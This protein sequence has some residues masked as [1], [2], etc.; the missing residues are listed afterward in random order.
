M[1]WSVEPIA[2]ISFMRLLTT[3]ISFCLFTQVIAQPCTMQGVYKIG[4]A[5]DYTTIGA[6]LT[7]LRNTGVGG[8][9]I[10]EI[11]SNYTN[12]NE[13][14]LSFGNIPCVS[15]A[16][17]ITL[18]PEAGATGVRISANGAIILLGNAHNVIIDGRPGGMG[19]TSELTLDGVSPNNGTIIFSGNSEVNTLRYVKITS[20]TTVTNLGTITFQN[21]GNNNNYI[22]NCYITGNGNGNPRICIYSESSTVKNLNNLIREC[23]ITRFGPTSGSGTGTGIYLGKN[24][25]GWLVTGNSFYA[26]GGPLAWGSGDIYAINMVDTTSSHS[27]YDNF[28]GGTAPQCGGQQSQVSHRFRGI[29]VAAGRGT[30]TNIDRNTIANLQ[31]SWAGLSGEDFAGIHI[32]SGKVGCGTSGGN[33]I[34]NMQ[35]NE[36]IKVV[37]SAASGGNVTGILLGYNLIGWPSTDTVL[38]INNKIGGIHCSTTGPTSSGMALRGI[39]VAEQKESFITI[40]DNKIG[41]ETLNNSL[42]SS[43]MSGAEVVGIDFWVSPNGPAYNEDYPPSYEIVNNRVAH[44]RGTTT[45]IRVN[46]GKPQ[47]INN[48]IRDM[49]M[50]IN[51]L[52]ILSI[53]GIRVLKA[54]TGSNIKGNRLFNLTLSPQQASGI[55]GIHLDNARGVDIAGNLMHNFQ[56]TSIDQTTTAHLS[57]IEGTAFTNR[58]NIYNNMISMG[59]DS[60][61]GPFGGNSEFIAMQMT[62]DTTNIMHNSIFIAGTGDV[63]A[64]GLLLT[65]KNNSACRVTNNIIQN[66]HS[67]IT[68]NVWTFN[69]AV[70]FDPIFTTTLNG[71]VMDYN[72]YNISGLSSF[73]GSYNNQRYATLPEWRVATAREVNSITGNPN[74]IKPAGDSLTTNMHIVLPTP[75]DAAGL[76]ET[77]VLRDFDNQVRAGLTPVDIGAD[78]ISSTPAPGIISFT[79]NNGGVGTNITITGTAFTNAT[80][81]SFGG[82]AASSFTVVNP[83]TITAV[84]G[85]GAT[86]SVSVT[87]PGGTASLAG[88]T[89]YPQPTITSFAPTSAGMGATVTITG[90]NFT[91]TNFVS[92]AGI[93]AASYTVVNA[94]TITAVVGIGAS[95]VINVQTPGGFATRS[96]FIFVG[97]PAIT[98]FAPTSGVTGTTVTIQGANFDGTTA[99]SFG[100]VPASSFTVLNDYIINAVVGAGATGDVSV[101]RAS[102]TGSLGVFTFLGPPTITSFSPLSASTGATVTITGNNFTGATAVSF[103]GTAAASFTVVNATTITAVVGAGASGAVSVTTPNGTGTLAGFTFVSGPGITSFAPTSAAAGATVTITGANFTGA[104]AVTFGGVAAASFTVVNAT[105]I[106]AVVGPGASGSVSVTTPGGTATLTGFTFIAG[107]GITS[108][109][110]TNAG[111]GTTVTITGTNFTGATAVTFGGVAAASFTIINSTSITAVVGTGASGSVSVTTPGGTATLTGFTFIPG[112]GITSFAPTTAAAGATVT[113]TGTNFTGATAVTF[114]GVAAASFTV[115]NATTITAVVGSGASGAVMVVTPGGTSS[116]AGFIFNIVTGVGGPGFNSPELTVSP[117]PGSAEI[118][119]KHPAAPKDIPIRLLDVLGKPVRYFTALRTTRSTIIDVR[120]LPPGYYILSWTYGSKTLTR[121]FLKQ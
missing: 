66:A 57:G 8:H 77:Y 18:R 39:Y 33:T 70:V 16:K 101:T 83:T 63:N 81:V 79:P 45:G 23:N 55:T 68:P 110:P 36:N 89:F 75:A 38:I 98:A 50:S 72:L 43:F 35:Q 115:V 113:I 37:S 14:L 104:T 85:A 56:V 21:G 105:T 61:G 62:I 69:N 116:L 112:P 6:A 2:K 47:V 88:F 97:P 15:S 28:I 119:V 54:I 32:I 96:G 1:S 52:T 74:F 71:L 42:V 3:V 108:F 11:K 26:D 64:T 4:P 111:A 100:G 86:G 90:T 106:T 17:T 58:I 44:C 10:L 95:G 107:P 12:I 25:D 92:F 120:T 48:Q 94:T 19:S 78:A 31:W 103:G 109:T 53:Y 99:V 27:I 7:A 102:G 118:V 24:S 51:D 121:T 87:T 40:S 49:N 76:D 80:A 46:G 30:Y 13:G 29:M 9:V 84:V 65:K 91:G 59:V 41:S 5:G 22:E 60:G 82:I 73:V 93:P 20:T 114:G 117:N 34:G 67:Q